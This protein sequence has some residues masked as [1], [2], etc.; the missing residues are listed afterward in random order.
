M[1]LLKLT[2]VSWG[3]SLSNTYENV[4][5]FE[6][7]ITVADEELH[8]AEAFRDQYL[9]AIRNIVDSYTAFLRIDVQNLTTP[10]GF[11]S[12]PLVGPPVGNRSGESMP[13]FVA[14]SFIYHRAVGGQRSG[15]KRFGTVSNTDVDIQEPTTAMLAV[16][17]AT[18]GTLSGPLMEGIVETWFPVILVRPVPPSTTWNRHTMSNVSFG[19]LSTQRTRLR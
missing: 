3:A 15:G 16:L 6:S 17:T 9:T 11:Y 8:L 1:S 12:L 14:W 5:G 19:R 4:F 10:T 7:F 13:E 18:A 2:L